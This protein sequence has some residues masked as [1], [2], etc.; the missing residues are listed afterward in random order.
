MTLDDALH[1]LRR[2]YRSV[3][4]GALGLLVAS[5]QFAAAVA[6]AA[7]CVIWAFLPGFVGQVADIELLRLTT[8]SGDGD[9]VSLGILLVWVIFVA[10]PVLL[11]AISY[12]GDTVTGGESA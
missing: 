8:A 10:V 4:E 11:A 9:L 12:F 3:G 1:A 5:I 6:L 2:S 7:A